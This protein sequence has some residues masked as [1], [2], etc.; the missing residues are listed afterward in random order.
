[1]LR[2]A[3]DPCVQKISTFEGASSPKLRLT[4]FFQ[5]WIPPFMTRYRFA[6]GVSFL[7]IAAASLPLTACVHYV[8]VKPEPIPPPVVDEPKPRAVEVTWAV[9]DPFRLVALEANQ[10]GRRDGTTKLLDRV[11]KYTALVASQVNDEG[12]LATWWDSSKGD[13]ASG[14]LHPEK[15]RVR[16]SAPSTLTGQCAWEVDRIPQPALACAQSLVI[17]CPVA[18]G[19]NVS[20]RDDAGHEGPSTLIHP[21][22]V[23]VATAGDS[24]ASGEGVPDV[25]SDHF[26]HL[27]TL[28][29]AR[30]MDKRCHRSLFSAHSIAGLIYT[31]MNP[32]VALTHVSY[33]CSGALL[34]EGF[35]D[36]Y[37]GADPEDS[38]HP[39]RPQ[40][41]M[42]RAILGGQ[43]ADFLTLSFGGND[44]S[45]API[46]ETATLW[47]EHEL[48]S[49]IGERVERGIKRLESALPKAVEGTA[50]FG[51][52]VILVGYPNPTLLILP[53]V[54]MH[55]TSI[56]DLKKGLNHCSGGFGGMLHFAPGPLAEVTHWWGGDFTALKLSMLDEKM[57]RPLREFDEK[58]GQQLGAIGPDYLAKD[59]T[60]AFSGHG[61]CAPGLNMSETRWINTVHDSWRTQGTLDQDGAMHPNIRGQV[62][63]AIRI[64]NRL[65][66]Y[67]CSDHALDA[68]FCHQPQA[69]WEVWRRLP[70][71]GKL[72]R[73][74]GERAVSNDPRQEHEECQPDKCA[75]AQKVAGGQ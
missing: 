20:V 17:E 65:V 8:D 64:L 62:A 22:N 72:A 53:D 18:C 13:Y 40:K 16:I 67:E 47:D 26:L 49:A 24:Y 68:E 25:R 31:Q 52:H 28:Y 6:R 2:G 34:T 59:V 15:I 7:V 50:G 58:L 33:A 35:I 14:Y 66:A 48:K 36:P 70:A 46:V 3:F 45:F 73:N 41:D 38:D 44:I 63:V 55:L 37:M 21:R 30:W 42:L 11:S 43:R 23:I 51:R 29:D 57:L 12:T 39:V 54:K 10:D 9:V 60:A 69:E 75:K 61:F 5:S 1:M 71:L 32:H 56:G 74:A 27:W 19:C 4:A